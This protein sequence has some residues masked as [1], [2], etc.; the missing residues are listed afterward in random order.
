MHVVCVCSFI[1]KCENRD[2][3]LV[4]MQRSH[5]LGFDSP[6]D[7]A[8]VVLLFVAVSARKAGFREFFCIHLPSD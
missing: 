2:L 5:D 1:C 6:C 3:Y 8:S 4:Y 7:K